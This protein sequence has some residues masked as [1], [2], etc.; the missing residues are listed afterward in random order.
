MDRAALRRVVWNAE[1]ARPRT[2]WRLIG[3][4]V[5]LV[6][7]FLVL[8]IVFRPVAA[9][10]RTWG[11]FVEVAPVTVMTV[12][13]VVFAA[14]SLASVL[15][16]A[17][18]LDRRTLADLGLGGGR[19]WWIDLGLGLALGGGLVSAIFLTKLVGGWIEVGAGGA[20]GHPETSL[21]GVLLVGVVMM[22]AVG[23][24]EEVL[25]R[26][27]YLVNLA[28]GL[29]GLPRLDPRR[30][31][32]LAAVAT[33]LGFG[34]VH[35][36]NPGATV[37][38]GLLVA[39]YGGYLAAAYLLTG[40]LALPIG[41][42][43]AWNYAQSFV[44]GFP[45]SGLDLAVGL[46]QTDPTGPAVLTGGAFGPEGGLVA[47]VWVLLSVPALVWWGRRRDRRAPEAAAEPDLRDQPGGR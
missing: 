8:A 42:H 1:E 16:A 40:D 14:V 37:A 6:V 41:F 38:H 35:S 43:V 46:L 2:P 21:A 5:L 7:L 47:L 30:A 12:D 24:W 19:E 34:L 36:F 29:R 9:V 10:A 4:T 45:V 3:Q 11:L 22:V 13:L 23:V 32:L 20:D 44:Y 27:Y 33:S 26:G 31:T 28:E 25:F 15:L 39:V 18:F 17:W